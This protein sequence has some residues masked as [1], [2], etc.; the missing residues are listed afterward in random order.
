MARW[1]VELAGVKARLKRFEDEVSFSQSFDRRMLLEQLAYPVL[2]GV[3]RDDL[4]VF[5]QTDWSG[6][7]TWWK[8]L[9]TPETV[10][11]YFSSNGLDPAS[12]P[13]LL[14]PLNAVIARNT[15]LEAGAPHVLADLGWGEM[16]VV[17]IS[18]TAATNKKVA[19]LDRGT[20]NW[21]DTTATLGSGAETRALG[22]NANDGYLYRVANNGYISRTNG[23]TSNDD[24]LS[25]GTVYP[26]AN[27]LFHFGSILY[28]DGNTL[29]KVNASGPSLSSYVD[30]GLGPD[31]LSDASFSAASRLVRESDIRTAISTSEGIFYVKNVYTSSGGVQPWLFR[32]DRDAAGNIIS[33]AIGTIPVGHVALAIGYFM[34]VPIVITSQDYQRL[35]ANDSS[36]GHTQTQLWAP[37]DGVIGLLGTFGER[38]PDET[39]ATF[40]GAE[41][42]RAFF[43]GTKRIWVYDGVR[44]GIH[45]FWN[46]AT[47]SDGVVSA[48]NRTALTNGSD[49][50][51]FA[52]EGGQYEVRSES[53]DDAATVVN[54]DSDLDT[55]HL[56]SNYFDFGLPLETKYITDVE[57]FIED[58][59]DS[60]AQWA[61]YLSVD[62]GAWT[63]IHTHP[64]ANTY[65]QTTGMSHGGRRFRYRLVYET[66]SATLKLGFRGIKFKA[67]AGE[68]VE[69][70]T[71]LIDGT[72]FENMDNKPLRAEDVYRSWRSLGQSASPVSFTHRFEELDPTASETLTVRIDS[73][74]IVKGYPEESMV[75]VRLTVV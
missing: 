75:R 32:V 58:G 45:P 46:P 37:L 49:L 24:W 47:I 43:G 66:K 11:H 67:V 44:G 69:T 15:P 6:G 70:I 5:H 63:K 30:D 68:Q 41:G 54:F 72:E 8:P 1:D 73:V 62:D 27:I 57:T 4:R 22:F 52:Y 61:V 65:A 14:R 28:W 40:L 53:Q 38:T 59:G 29:R 33:N 2:S 16:R 55:Y 3:S 31:W 35:V 13:G 71:L 34:G 56:E 64:G 74:Q 12:E 21:T 20:G 10:S 19:Y 39:V 60:N 18:S 7:A 36:Q 51:V 9:L 25:V 42:H 17:S 23:T 26:G 48:A 50:R